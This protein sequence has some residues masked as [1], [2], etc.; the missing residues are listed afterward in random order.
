MKHEAQLE[1]ASRVPRWSTPSHARERLAQ[2]IDSFVRAAAEASAEPGA[3]LALKVTA[4]LGKTATALR[5]VARY[6]EALLSRGHVLIYV[7]TIELAERAFDDFRTLAPGLP[8]RVIRGRDAPRPDERQKTM[9]ERAEIAK[10]IS[11]YVASVTEALCRG[12]DKNGDFVRS[13]CASGCPYL[14]QKDVPGPHVVFLSHAYLTVDPPLDY[15][16]PVVLRVVDE[17]VWPTLTRTPHL[18]IDDLMRASPSSFPESLRGVLTRAKATV[19]DGLQRDLPLHDHLRNSGIGTEQLQHLAQAEDRSR[20]YLEIGPWQSAETVAFCVETFDAKS[21][22]ASRRRQRIFERLAERETGHCVGLRL[23]EKTTEHG[24][25]RVIQSSGIHEVDRDAPLLLLDADADPDITQRVAPGAELVSIQSPPVADVV[26]ISDLTLSNSWLLHLE[27]GAQRRA[28]VLT[29]LRREVN[30]AA[31]GG[32]LVVA[33]KSVLRALHTDLGNSLNGSDE[34][35][36]RQPLLGAEPR[37]FGPRTQGVNDFE[38]YASVVII[39]RLQPGVAD[40][41]AS[42]RAVFAQD[43]LPIRAHVSGPLPPTRSRMIM[44]DGSVRE[45]DLRAHPDPRVQAILAQSRECGTL[46]AI[47]R[48]RLLSPNRE[49]RVVVLSNLPLPD[50]PITRLTTL[51]A[52]DRDLEQ[53]P[54]WYGFD[55]ME[56]ALRATMGRPVCGTRLS[57]A[58]L[59]ADLPRDFETEPG[60]ARF[61]RGRPTAHLMSL[62][63]RVAA[64]NRWQITALVLRRATGGKPVPAIIL[65]DPA[66]LALARR[67]WPD[68]TPQ[69]A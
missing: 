4:G 1:A 67:L 20:S 13:P 6:G 22:I 49:K 24:S 48:L 68:F 39:G 66:P 27:R 9:C 11:G 47:A 45:A 3:A 52:L 57:A 43:E 21:F 5:V 2:E 60:A 58:G 37:W 32:V 56:K 55:R 29:I 17:K 15:D 23:L 61:R 50:F 18:S 64:A 41:E 42:A 8:S 7:P 59:A 35:A 63:Q 51:A 12:Q 38:S 53:E 36:L 44:A 10:K 62:C 46:Q 65:D 54:D 69:L 31:G 16:Y 30:R 26:Q 40:I 14:Q 19:V 33:T 34:E 25:E 28:A